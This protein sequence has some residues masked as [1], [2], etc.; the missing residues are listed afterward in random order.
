MG[1]V[2]RGQSDNRQGNG[3]ARRIR[4]V[5][6]LM[7]LVGLG[8]GLVIGGSL[9]ARAQAGQ[10]QEAANIAKEVKEAP[11]RYMKNGEKPDSTGDGPY[12]A[13]KRQI[14]GPP[15]LVAYYPKN[16]A[17]LGGHKMPIYIFGNGACS[18]DGA[19]SRQ[20]PL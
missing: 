8:G 2:S 15:D 4:R 10:D 18:N 3:P 9:R 7:V 12:P 17:A 20:H 5:G 11:L 14:D 1:R 13:I 19:S 16:L 6:V